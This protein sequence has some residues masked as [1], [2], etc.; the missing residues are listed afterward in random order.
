MR[1]GEL[2]IF[3]GSSGGQFARRMSRYMNVETGKTSVFRF[4]E[5]NTFVKVNE[6]IREQDFFLVHPIALDPNNEFME[7]VFWI[8]AAKRASARSV[9]VIMPY[10]SYAKADK[11]DEPRV[12]I[13]GRVCADML[14]KVGADRIITMD[15]HS[16]QVQGFFTKPVD[17]L[18]A[19]P[20][21]VQRIEQYKLDNLVVVSPDAGFVADARKYANRLGTGLVIG[22]KFRAS[23]D[24]NAEIMEIIGDVK[25]KNCLLV[26]DFSISGGTLCHL[27]ERLKEQGALRIFASLSHILLNEKG[28][29]RIEDSPIEKLISTDSVYNEAAMA[30]ETIDL[31]SVAPLFAEA[32]Q[33][34]VARESLGNLFDKIPDSV[35]R[36][37]LLLANEE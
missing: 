7:L 2:K 37:S 21:L 11:K 22:N 34:I 5:G 24:E 14:E 15:L 28:V 27:A 19:M 17:H 32:V 1:K 36:Q 25:G 12:S 9:T 6:P 20:L 29:K 16:P 30:S 3:A 18:Y 31:I 26:D 35:F 10:F 23:H 13:R 4:S 8:D 33:R